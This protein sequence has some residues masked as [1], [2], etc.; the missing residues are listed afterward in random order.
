MSSTLQWLQAH[1]T[2]SYHLLYSNH[3][4]F[5]QFLEILSCYLPQAGM[6]AVPFVW[7]VLHN[8]LILH[9]PFTYPLRQSQLKCLRPSLN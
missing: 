5:F 7:N 8:T 4:I 6:H 3:I 2:M 1:L 9:K